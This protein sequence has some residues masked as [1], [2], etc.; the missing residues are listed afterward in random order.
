MAKPRDFSITI[1]PDGQIV[2]EVDGQQETAYKRILEF[3]EETVG[4]AQALELAPADPPERR[5][6]QLAAE[7]E[8]EAEK[9]RLGKRA[10]E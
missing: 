1:R 7:A 2:L 9:L 10:P 4:P 3:L 5:L 6:N 8:R